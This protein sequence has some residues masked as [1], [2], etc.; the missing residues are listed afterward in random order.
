[1]KY[2]KIEIFRILKENENDI[3]KFGIKRIG[4]FG[5]YVRNQQSETS[6]IDFAVEF[7]RE[8]KTYKNYIKLIHY[9]ED[10][11]DSDI[12]LVTL[13]SLPKNRNFTENVLKETE[14][15]TL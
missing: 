1:M 4:L 2:T 14:Y 13:K 3:K 11:F 12:D 8:K 10:L 9:L 7:I 5:S 15:V 6:D